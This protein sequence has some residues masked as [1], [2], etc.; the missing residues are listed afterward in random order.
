MGL[1][2]HTGKSSEASTFQKLFFPNS[3]LYFPN[4]RIHT[5]KGK[6]TEKHRTKNHWEGEISH[7][8]K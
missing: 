1:Q 2:T 4:D 7:S 3:I 5:P 6:S 8:L